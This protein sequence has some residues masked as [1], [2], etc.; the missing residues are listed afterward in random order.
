ML[1][2]G[3]LGETLWVTLTCVIGVAALAAAITGHVSLPLSGRERAAYFICSLGLIVPE[4]I[5]DVIGSVLLV[6]VLWRHLARA[7]RSAAAGPAG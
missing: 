5:T 2:I 1:F 4:K 7:R 6:A 3:A